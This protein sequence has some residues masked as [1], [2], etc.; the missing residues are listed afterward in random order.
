MKS[1]VQV[2]VAGALAIPSL[3]FGQEIT[4][5]AIEKPGHYKNV[6]AREDISVLGELRIVPMRGAT[7]V[8]MSPNFGQITLFKSAAIPD[9]ADS[10]LSTLQNRKATVRVTGSLLMLCTEKE[11]RQ[12]N[13]VGCREFDNTKDITIAVR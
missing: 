3:V 5:S 7:W 11:L 9:A 13:I 2:V 10:Q 6:R 1:V 12:E 4:V 8:L